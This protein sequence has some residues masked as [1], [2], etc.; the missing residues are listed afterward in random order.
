M[1]DM[2]TDPTSSASPQ[3][4]REVLSQSRAQL[5]RHLALGQGM[6][7]AIWCN[8]QDEVHYQRQLHHTVS[9][10]LAGGQGSQ[11]Q[12]RSDALGAAGRMCVLPS[13]HESQWLVRAPVQFLHL[14]VSDLAWADRVVRLLDAEPRSHT[15]SPHIYI[16]DPAYAR[17]AQALQQLAWGDVHAQ[18]L[19][20]SWSQHAL[21]CLVQRVA[22]PQQQQALLRQTQGGLA[23]VA[24]RHVL[25]WIDVHLSDSGALRVTVL[26]QQA[27]LSEFHF[28][29]MFQRSMGCSVHTW[30]MHCRLQ[31]VCQRL[32]T[33]RTLPALA[34]LAQ[35]GGFSHASHLL[36]SFRQAY[37]VTPAQ[38]WQS[39]AHAHTWVLYKKESLVPA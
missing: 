18:W 25:E 13:G 26:A 3:H 2:L 22:T 35:Q 12:G 36:R 19:A 9:V 1:L 31:R 16:Q 24:R 28:A 10:Y 4:L 8:A 27:N 23:S 32:Q 7:L 37:G 20:D 39:Q 14:Y 30:V 34:E 29:R 38:W 11:L 6:E 15:L 33:A 17:W 21:D 5:Q